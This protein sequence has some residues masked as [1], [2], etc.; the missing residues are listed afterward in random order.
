[1]QVCIRLLGQRLVRIVMQALG[2]LPLEHRL[3]PNVRRVMLGHGRLQLEPRFHL[4]VSCVLLVHGQLR[5]Q[6]L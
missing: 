2:L 5:Q 1:M 6:Q 4:S 3:L